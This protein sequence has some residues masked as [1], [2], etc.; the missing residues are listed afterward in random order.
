MPSGAPLSSQPARVVASGSEVA[1]PQASITSARSGV[2]AGAVRCLCRTSSGAPRTVSTAALTLST[3]LSSS[4]SGVSPRRIALAG[5]LRPGHLAKQPRSNLCRARPTWRAP[6]TLSKERRGFLSPP[7]AWLFCSS[8]S[9]LGPLGARA[10]N[11][12]P[13]S[14]SFHK[15][16]VSKA[17]WRMPWKRLWATTWLRCGG[18][19]PWAREAQCSPEASRV[20]LPAVLS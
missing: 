20:R 15:S 13:G 17:R 2:C 9:V 14:A 7:R 8:L 19:S 6:W 4:S 10:W 5:S 18:Y 16:S 1:R 12:R 11:S 3:S